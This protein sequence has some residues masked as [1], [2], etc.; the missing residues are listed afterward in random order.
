MAAETLMPNGCWGP[1]GLPCTKLPHVTI[2]AELL[3]KWKTQSLLVVAQH[4]LAI[5]LALTESAM[6]AC[7]YCDSLAA[8]AIGASTVE[9][10]K[11]RPV[12]S[13]WLPERF[14]LLA[15]IQSSSYYSHW[16][17]CCSLQASA[18]REA[19]S[20]LSLHFRRAA[21][22]DVPSPPV[23]FAAEFAA[24]ELRRNYFAPRTRPSATKVRASQS[25][26]SYQPLSN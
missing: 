18:P 10:A 14:D 8:C 11:L 19:S 5:A 26:S 20:V 17:W 7:H 13:T 9:L 4:H 24:A 2:F 1:C 6:M 16:N 23:P 21:A 22:L 25:T 15:L 3:I 12:Q